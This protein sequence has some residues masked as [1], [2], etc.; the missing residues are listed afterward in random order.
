[1]IMTST[2]ICLLR[3]LYIPATSVMDL[4]TIFACAYSAYTVF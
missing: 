3:S 1:M 4:F 2:I